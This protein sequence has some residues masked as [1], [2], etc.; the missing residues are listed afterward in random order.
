M[1]VRDSHPWQQDALPPSPVLEKLD[2]NGD[3]KLDSADVQAFFDAYNSGDQSV[4]TDLDYDLNNDGTVDIADV[5]WMH[6]NLADL[7]QK[8]SGGSGGNGAPPPQ[9]AGLPAGP[10]L[11]LVVVAAAWWWANRQ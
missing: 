2:F 8:Y 3:G 9:P 4:L 11:V 10:V 1:L 7:D 5:Q 6:A